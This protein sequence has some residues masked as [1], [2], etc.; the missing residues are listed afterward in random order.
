MA[1]P[2]LKI[3]G[4]EFAQETFPSSQ[5]YSRVDGG[6]NLHRK[7][8]GAGAQQTHWNKLAT[9]IS[10]EG[11]SPAAL[12]G[13]DWSTSVEI[14]CIQPRAIHSSSNVAT[15]PAARRSDLTVNVLAYAVVGGAL[16]STPV[17]VVTNTA[18]A[19][20]VSGATSYQFYYFPKANFFSRGPVLDLDLEGAVYGWSLEAEE[21]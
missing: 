3:A 9:R 6:S 10:G 2:T 8:S 19:T 17:N 4:V 7:L 13:V 5:T 21:A 11:W 15:L 20:T 12:A 14:L 1:L 16:V 18:T